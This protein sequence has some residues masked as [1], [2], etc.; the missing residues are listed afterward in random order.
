MFTGIIQQMGRVESIAPNA[1]WLRV[2][3]SFKTGD[4]VA[5]NGTCLTVAKLKKKNGTSSLLFQTSEETMAK[6]TLG[7]LTVGGRANIETPLKFKELM[8]GHFVTGHIEGLGHVRKILKRPHSVEVWYSGPKALFKYIAPKGSI[9]VDGVSLT[10]VEVTRDT[11]SVSLIP[12][13]LKNTRLGQLKVGDPVNLETDVLAKYAEKLLNRRHS[14]PAPLTPSSL[15]LLPKGRRRQRNPLFPS[16][17]R[18][19]G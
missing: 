9:A 10:V 1:L 3:G 19:R 12:F 7:H 18:E 15:I 2:R 8:G 16:P 14:P 13:T 17:F 11:F 4:S 6:T 5:V